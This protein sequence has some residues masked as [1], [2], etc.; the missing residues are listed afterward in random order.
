[1]ACAQLLAMCLL[2]AKPGAA[3]RGEPLPIFHDVSNGARS[4]QGAAPGGGGGS[5]RPSL[6]AGAPGGAA[7]RS[8]GWMWPCGTRGGARRAPGNAGGRL[9]A[10]AMGTA[11]A[12]GTSKSP[13]DVNLL[14]LPSPKAVEVVLGGPRLSGHRR[15]LVAP[16]RDWGALGCG[17][18]R[19]Q[20]R[21]LKAAPG[22]SPLVHVV[23]RAP[24]QPGCFCCDEGS[25]EKVIEEAGRDRG[26]QMRGR[27]AGSPC[28]DVSGCA[29]PALMSQVTSPG[30]H[31]GIRHC[32]E[33]LTSWGGEEEE[34]S[35]CDASLWA[36]CEPQRC[37]CSSF[38]ADI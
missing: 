38:S 14:L 22:G 17:Q 16:S 5:S 21:G 27:K 13:R 18:G 15:D 12:T 23:E 7:P 4:G 25:E 31:S 20:S 35:A 2:P 32:R 34:G 28:L 6:R 29:R 37:R 33:L 11:S 30:Q 9:A 3:P 26:G 1:M 10:P 8:A 19:Q 36:L 24:G